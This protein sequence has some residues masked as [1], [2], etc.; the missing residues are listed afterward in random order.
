MNELLPRKIKRTLTSPLLLCAVA[1]MVVNDHVLKW[2]D[3]LPRTITGKLSDFAFLFFVPVVVA[4]GF[5]VKTRA[6]LVLSYALVGGLFAGINLSAHFSQMV[7]KLFAAVAVPLFLWPDPTDLVA[8]SVMP[9]SLWFLAR[10]SN[11]RLALPA[12]SLQFGVVLVC[13]IAGAASSPRYVSHEP[14]YMSWEDFRGAVEIQPPR[15][16]KKR[17]KIYVKDRYLYVNEPNKGI[18]IFDNTDPENPVARGFLNIPGNTDLSIKGSFLYADSYVDLL[19]FALTIHPEDIVLIKR[20][21]DVF[22]Y[23]PNQ[24]RPNLEAADGGQARVFRPARVDKSKGVVSGWR[25][26]QRR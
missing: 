9:L 26:V 19:V 1:L 10:E 21:E 3:L 12:K 4:F 15:E 6:G 11:M 8:L 7:E 25:P 16:I 13:V 14:V 23:D 20:V 22:P 17:G 24:N 18:H 5:R 2:V